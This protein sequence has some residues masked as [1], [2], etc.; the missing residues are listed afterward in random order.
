MAKQ[1]VLRS[2][3]ALNYIKKLIPKS[4]EFLVL[5]ALLEKGYFKEVS[6]N[7]Y[8]GEIPQEQ[9][10]HLSEEIKKVKLL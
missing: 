6:P 1:K 5:P 3:K 4:H 2:G 7:Q 10:L 9:A 8:S